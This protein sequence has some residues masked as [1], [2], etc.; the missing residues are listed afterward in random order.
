VA[1][2]WKIIFTYPGG[3]AK[4]GSQKVYKKEC[5]ENPMFKHYREKLDANF[6]D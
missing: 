5:L 3:Q 2:I 6:E 4:R 1:L